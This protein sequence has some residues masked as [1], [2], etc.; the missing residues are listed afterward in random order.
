MDKGHSV[1]ALLIYPGFPGC[2]FNFEYYDLTL[3]DGERK[4]SLLLQSSVKGE[5]LCR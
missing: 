5:I 1:K 2:P 3:L 4:V